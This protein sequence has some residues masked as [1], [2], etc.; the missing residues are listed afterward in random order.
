[1]VIKMLYLFRVLLVALYVVSGITI[2][3]FNLIEDPAYWSLFGFIYGV[4]A[5]GLWVKNEI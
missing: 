3:Y 4:I 2:E 1:M 5:A